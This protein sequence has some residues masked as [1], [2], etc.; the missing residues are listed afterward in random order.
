MLY[1]G[2]LRYWYFV[3]WSDD[4]VVRECSDEAFSVK[5]S[6]LVVVN[7]LLRNEAKPTR[8]EKIGEPDTPA[9]SAW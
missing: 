2:S 1:L 9:C 6:S 4:E 3:T 5:S 7:V 8:R